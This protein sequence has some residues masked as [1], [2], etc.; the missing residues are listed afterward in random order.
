[1]ANTAGRQYP[2]ADWSY[3]HQKLDCSASKHN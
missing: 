3:D 1:M 2:R